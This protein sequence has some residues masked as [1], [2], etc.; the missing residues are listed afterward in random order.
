L[1]QLIVAFFFPFV[2][3]FLLSLKDFPHLTIRG[4]LIDLLLKNCKVAFL[5][6]ISEVC[7]GIDRGKI[8]CI[9]FESSMPEADRTIDLEGKVV[10]P[11]AVD[12]HVH[13]F[14]PGWIRETFETGTKAAAVGGVTT[15]AD[16][17]SV[18]EWQTVNVETFRKKLERAEKEAVVDFSLYC[19]EIYKKEDLKEIPEILRLG[20]VGLGEIMMCEPDPIPDSMVLLEA[21]RIASKERTFIALHAEDKEIIQKNVELMRKRGRQDLEAFTESRPA[22][23]ESKAVLDAAILSSEANCPVHICHLSSEKGVEAL[24]TAKKISR[25]TAE[26]TPHHLLLSSKDYEKLGPLMVATPP[27]REKNDLL[28]LWE[29]LSSGLIDAMASDHCAFSRREKEEAESIWSVPPGIP[30]LETM[31]PLLW[32]EGVRKGRISLRRFIEATSLRPAQILGI[33]PRKGTIAF[34]Y[35]ADLAVI[36]QKARW[37]IGKEDMVCIADY[38]PFDG[39]EVH[40]RIVMTIVR[41]EIVAEE[42]SILAK[43]GYGNFIPRKFFSES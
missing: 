43:P 10:V 13:V 11:G 32:S 17:S 8:T 19:G 5:E 20:A 25:V 37:R 22:I 40:G 26:T 38:T 27:V 30:G 34:G 4:A 2:Y 14:S 23:A 41:G 42:G 36:D 24:R 1:F 35:D 29:G 39:Y 28:A 15:I 12:A 18:G 6:G 7:L 33:Y 9:G 3:A 21:M 31:M 16:M